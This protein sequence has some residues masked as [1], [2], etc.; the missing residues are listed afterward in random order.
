MTKDELRLYRSI[1]IEI[2]QLEERLVKLD[3]T[4]HNDDI[5][6]PLRELYRKKL[7]TLIDGQLKIEQAI[8]SL[9]PTERELMRMRYIDG[10]EWL[11]ISAAIHYEWT[12][13]HRIHSRAL[14]KI[15]NL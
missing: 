9:D 8:E 12:Q 3:M 7:K 13:T 11:D 5:T 15:K 14:D 6:Q 1:S 4:G 2:C 10:Y